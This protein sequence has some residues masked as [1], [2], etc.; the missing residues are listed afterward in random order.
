MYFPPTLCIFRILNNNPKM[1]C[2]YSGKQTFHFVDAVIQQEWEEQIRYVFSEIMGGDV[3][4][5]QEFL[6]K[7]D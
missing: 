3:E 2:V 7:T 6:F 1:F 5:N 4:T